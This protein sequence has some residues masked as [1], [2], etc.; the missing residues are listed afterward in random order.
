MRT[1]WRY[2]RLFNSHLMKILRNMNKSIDKHI[3]E[4]K[5][6]AKKEGQW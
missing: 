3:D 4:V 5:E 1:L 2:L 6:Q